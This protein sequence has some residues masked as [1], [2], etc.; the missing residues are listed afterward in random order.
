MLLAKKRRLTNREKKANAQ[1]RKQ[2]QQ[3]GI[4]PPDKPKLDRKKFLQAARE[5]WGQ[6]DKDCYIWDIYLMEAI[7]LMLSKKES[8]SGRVSLEAVGVAKVL[9]LAIRISKF[10][11]MVAKRAD[12]KY[13]I[14]EKYEY[15]KDI[16]D[17]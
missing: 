3:E 14:G 6:R 1:V 11:D 15:I 17:A 13:T 7:S 5:E 16:L 10:E 8:I 4:L 9:R 12:R 2:L